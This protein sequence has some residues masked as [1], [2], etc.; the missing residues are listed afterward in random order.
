MMIETIIVKIS[1]HHNIIKIGNN[2]KSGHVEKYQNKTI[3]ELKIR[4]CENNNTDS[5]NDKIRSLNRRIQTQF[6]FNISNELFC[7][8]NKLSKITASIIKLHLHL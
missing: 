7:F 8:S 4:E 1:S 3:M 2:S 6:L 5:Y